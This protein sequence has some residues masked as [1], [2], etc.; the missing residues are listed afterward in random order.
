ESAGPPVPIIPVLI[1]PRALPPPAGTNAPPAP[2]R[3]HRRPQRFAPAETPV[4]PLVAPVEEAPKPAP[5]AP[6]P[7]A[8][9]GPPQEPTTTNLRATLRG[10][11][12]C[13]NADALR[14]SREE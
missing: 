2:I 5:T 9:P 11:L 4:A 13:Q 8:A 6:A 14:L 1:M 12:G 3:L 7:K 10:R